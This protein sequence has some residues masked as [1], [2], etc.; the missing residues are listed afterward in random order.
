M[1]GDLGG[2]ANAFNQGFAQAQQ[3]ALTRA[4]MAQQQDLIDAQVSRAQIEADMAELEKDQV[5]RGLQAEEL[6][7]SLLRGGPFQTGKFAADDQ[8][9][10]PN[11][12]RRQF[13]DP[14]SLVRAEGLLDALKKGRAE[15]EAIEAGTEG[16]RADTAF[17]RQR[18]EKFGPRADVETEAQRLANVA[19]Q[20]GIDLRAPQVAQAQERAD[21]EL[22]GAKTD[23]E[24]RK[25][26]LA[27]SETQRQVEQEIAPFQVESFLQ[28]MEKV[29]AE[30]NQMES[31]VDLAK[32]EEAARRA[33]ETLDNA[34]REAV[35]ADRKGELVFNAQAS[36][37]LADRQGRINWA[38][39]QQGFGHQ[40][41]LAQEAFEKSQQGKILQHALNLR[42]SAVGTQ[43]QL[44]LARA[45]QQMATTGN[46]I[47]QDAN[48]RATLMSNLVA[49]G[50][51]QN[52]ARR[53]VERVMGNTYAAHGKVMELMA[54][55]SRSGQ[56][57]DM[58]RYFQASE[59]LQDYTDSAAAAVAENP[60][61]LL[62]VLDQL[63]PLN[64]EL[65][66]VGGLTEG[67][68]APAA[69]EPLDKDRARVETL[70]ASDA[71]PDVVLDAVD[72]AGGSA[73]VTVPDVELMRRAWLK[74]PEST[75]TSEPETAK[76]RWVENL[77]DEDTG[78]KDAWALFNGNPVRMPEPP[79][80]V[81]RWWPLARAPRSP[82]KT[83]WTSIG[84]PSRSSTTA[85][86][87][88]SIT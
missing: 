76:R 37:A 48:L 58:E 74:V 45:T 55:A 24:Q 21:T 60:K 64:S 9:A 28:G 75:R 35:R 15:V 83:T 29:D 71:M 27:R 39:A 14:I 33:Q 3:N 72:A 82:K 38:L 2:F 16:T 84:R 34:Y 13:A 57:N 51:P 80:S 1:S 88:W 68:A 78:G 4:Q 52:K 56:P 17:T 32:K 81:T 25:V 31:S 5:S 70:L 46:L 86:T 18:S 11:E 43:Q 47:T 23:V 54:R 30:I 36:M 10:D 6:A 22:E 69:A 62:E 26:D 40:K 8:P 79:R 50:T 65:D 53:L 67:P 61:R 42:E 73:A 44:A 49:A 59:I 87:T 77:N 66:R 19:T 41:T 63:Q 85:W 20:Q 7:G 12:V